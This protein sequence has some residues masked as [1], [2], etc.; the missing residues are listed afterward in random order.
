[1][2]KTCSKCHEA[3]PDTDFW[4]NKHNKDGLNGWCTACE[5]AHRDAN[6]ERILERRHKHYETNKARLAAER[7][8]YYYQH[9][10]EET[11]RARA[12][13]KSHANEIAE[14]RAAHHEEIAARG[15]AW[16]K[17][18]P[19]EVSQ[20]STRRRARLLKATCGEV[21][22]AA[23]LQRDGWTCYLCGELI[24]RETLSFDHVIPLAKGGEHSMGNIK[25]AHLRCNQRKSAKILEPAS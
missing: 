24:T 14:Y 5:N 15:R 9:Q 13:L 21:S 12:Y 16:D 6:R 11:S 7:R 17:A 22:Y 23:I 3:K 4:K 1:M 18:H 20:K 19:L 10:A 2:S 8:G 25:P